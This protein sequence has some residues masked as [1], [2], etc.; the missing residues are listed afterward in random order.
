MVIE[1]SPLSMLKAAEGG[2]L[3]DLKTEVEKADYIVFK[4]YALPRPRLKIRSA[5]KKLVEVDEGKIA[6][7]EYS[8]FYTVINAALQGRK[9][10]FKEFA[11]LVG[12]W[13]A[14]AGYLSVLWR[15]GLVAFDDREKVLKMYTAFFSLSQKG[16][17]RRIAKSLDS[18]FTLNVEAIEKLPSDKLTCVFKNNKL[19]CRYIVSETERSQA[20][21]EVKA[22]SDILASLK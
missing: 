17:E 1:I 9:P 10:T 13:K 18:T 16:Y 22:V 8:L 15:L 5:K 20:K 11:D 7:L 12:D 3:K 19:G 14:A 6:R 4:V 2:K 21:A